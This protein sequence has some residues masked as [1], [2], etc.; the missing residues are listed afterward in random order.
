MNSTRQADGDDISDW[1]FSSAA[2]GV[3]CCCFGARCATP[4]SSRATKLTHRSKPPA[5]PSLP[6]SASTPF[7]LSEGDMAQVPTLD[8]APTPAQ[9]LARKYQG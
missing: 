8:P 3:W 7:K 1:S 2:S 4:S 5:D 6:A 9:L